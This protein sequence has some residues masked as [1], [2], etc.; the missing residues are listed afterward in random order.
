MIQNDQKLKNGKELNERDII[1]I[2]LNNDSEEYLNIQ[3]HTIKAISMKK[4]KF[5]NNYQM[6]QSESDE[7][8]PL[9]KIKRSNSVDLY[10][11]HNKEKKLRKNKEN[12]EIINNK[13]MN[14]N[15]KNDKNGKKIK[16]VSFLQPTFVTIID[17]ESYKKFNQ[18]NTS[19]DPY[20][21]LINKINNNNNDKNK[22]DNQKERVVCSCY[23]F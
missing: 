15:L 12:N 10:K 4:I 16:T 1:D 13:I 19:K 5:F 18:D 14:N 8:V 9:P 3:S 17:V 7:D 11:K 23:I 2:I 22:E 6:D 21:D 20:G